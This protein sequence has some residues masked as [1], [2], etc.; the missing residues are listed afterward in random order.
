MLEENCWQQCYYVSSQSLGPI[1]QEYLDWCDRAFLDLNV[2]KTKEM[3]IS[4]KHIDTNSDS[5]HQRLNCPDL[6]ILWWWLR[7]S[8]NTDGSVKK[9]LQRLYCLHKLNS[10]EGD[11]NVFFFF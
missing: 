7:F 8:K 2:S 3:I 6:Q 1:M 11:Q 5:L 10:F 4:P 9:T